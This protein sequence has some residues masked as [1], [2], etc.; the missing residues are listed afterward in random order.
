MRNNSIFNYKYRAGATNKPGQQGFTLVELM[1]VVAII[2]ILAAIGIPKMTTFIRAAKASEATQ[3]MGRIAAGLEAYNDLK[4]TSTLP[5]AKILSITDS[6]GGA[7][8]LDSLIPSITIDSDANFY[9]T[10]TSYTVTDSLAYCI[11][12]TPEATGESAY[13]IY[14]SRTE[15]DDDTDI[16]WD[17]HFSTILYVTEGSATL[18]AAGDCTVS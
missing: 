5:A 7:S 3:M 6:A 15:A 17:G 16:G 13:L 10:V 4:P 2:A 18:A 11:T 14:Y 12:A 9:Y 1:V 8:T